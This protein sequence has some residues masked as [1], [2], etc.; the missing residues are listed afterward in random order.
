MTVAHELIGLIGVFVLVLVLAI[1]V[2]IALSFIIVGFFGIIYVDD[3]SGAL[4]AMMTIPYRWAV[5]YELAPVV[6]FLLMAAIVSRG[7][8]A[9]SLYEA[10]TKWLGRIRGSLAVATVLACGAFATVSGSS[11][12][13]AGAMGGI[14][15]PEMKKRKYDMRMAAGAAAA[16]GTIGILIPPSIP[17]IVYGILV[18]ESIGR[19]FI[20]GVIPGIMEIISYALTIFIIVRIRP[21]WAPIGP[22]YTFR[23]K[24]KSLLPVWAVLVLALVIIG[25]I[26]GGVFTPTEA[27]AI[28]ASTAFLIVLLTRHTMTFKDFVT[29]LLEAGSLSASLF[30]IIIGAMIFNRFMVLS[31]LIAKVGEVAAFFESP[32]SF[33]L[34]MAG[35]YFILGCFIEPLPMIILTLPI[36]LPILEHLAINLIWF[37]IVAVRMMEVGLITPPVGMNLFTISAVNP[38]IRTIEII[39]GVLPFLAADIVCI[40]LLIFF[41]QLS[42]FL[43]GKM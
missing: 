16:G 10:V 4:S 32:A 21:Q 42:L 38:D 17:L 43:P 7:G 15:L 1:G 31:G 40:L 26:Y 34:F 23:A 13:T 28:G 22:S 5:T 9:E 27:G 20:A 24:M 18:E 29:A 11:I 14:A 35:V 41:P 37:A 30:M 6:L 8:V 25:G 19:L 33:L 3:F 2:P 39:K 36:V 12:A